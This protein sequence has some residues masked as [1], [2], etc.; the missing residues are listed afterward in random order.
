MD[1]KSVRLPVGSCGLAHV[2][3]SDKWTIVEMGLQGV[4]QTPKTPSK[5]SEPPHT[6]RR[7]EMG[8]RG[9]DT[10]HRQPRAIRATTPVSMRSTVD[11]EESP[12][13]STLSYGRLGRTS[14]FREQTRGRLGEVVRKIVKRMLPPSS[15]GESDVSWSS[16]S[17]SSWMEARG[18]NRH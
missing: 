16:G 4:P 14:R 18:W 6:P 12:C 7:A 1:R 8:R 15:G 2:L 3:K 13:L 10:P 5:E 17:A 11:S 9:Y